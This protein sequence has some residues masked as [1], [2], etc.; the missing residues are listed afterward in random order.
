MPST[1]AGTGTATSSWRVWRN[2]DSCSST[3]LASMVIS[4]MSSPR[5]CVVDGTVAYDCRGRHWDASCW[6]APAM[7]QSSLVELQEGQAGL[8][9]APSASYSSVGTLPLFDDLPGP[10]RKGRADAHRKVEKLR[11][12]GEF[13]QGLGHEAVGKAN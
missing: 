2:P 11:V 3:S 7:R 12:S 9:A 5:D 8:P 1:K 6:R 10:R 4:S 13:P